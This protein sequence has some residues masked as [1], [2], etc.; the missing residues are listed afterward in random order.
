M[1][2]KIRG[3]NQKKRIIYSLNILVIKLPENDVIMVQKKISDL[4][5]F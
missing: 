5:S 3:M 2:I 1:E 4:V